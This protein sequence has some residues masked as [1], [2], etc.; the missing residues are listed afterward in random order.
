MLPGTGQRRIDTVRVQLKP[1]HALAIDDL[2]ILR[3]LRIFEFDASRNT[4]IDWDN[5][6]FLD[7]R[8]D[9]GTPQALTQQ[10]EDLRESLGDPSSKRVNG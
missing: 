4:G 1:G 5:T 9:F 10:L 6:V 3:R 7:A 8:T 2:S